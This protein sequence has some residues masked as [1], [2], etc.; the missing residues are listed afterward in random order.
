MIL[1][2]LAAR[3]R[4]V[5][6]LETVRSVL[7]RTVSS[8][9]SSTHFE[10]QQTPTDRVAGSLRTACSATRHCHRSDPR[11]SAPWRRSNSIG[12][13][14]RVAPF[15]RIPVAPHPHARAGPQPLA[16]RGRVPGPGHVRIGRC[17]P[18]TAGP[19]CRVGRARSCRPISFAGGG[20]GNRGADRS[21]CHD[22]RPHRADHC[23]PHDCG[24]R[25]STDLFPGGC[26]TAHRADRGR[27]GRRSAP[28]PTGVQ[29]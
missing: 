27:S 29:R 8:H 14:H 28:W 11:R 25:R 1:L 12:T 4:P 15:E 26:A 6:D 9:A 20:A 3:F 18:R 10:W 19:A 23:S 21:R 24:A 5:D 22:H 17:S 2:R 16:R 13:G 7:E